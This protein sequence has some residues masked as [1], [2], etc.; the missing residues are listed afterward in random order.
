MEEGA[1]IESINDLK[2]RFEHSIG[3]V[4]SDSDVPRP[5]GKSVNCYE[6]A[7]RLYEQRRYW[8]LV[9]KD[10]KHYQAMGILVRELIKQGLEPVSASEEGGLVVYRNDQCLNHVGFVRGRL[11]RSKWG[12]GGSVWDHRPEEVPI[13]FG[14]VMG[15]YRAPTTEHVVEV[16][17][18]LSPERIQDWYDDNW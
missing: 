2:N 17:G 8:D 12:P 4:L 11:V 1:Q 14:N 6:Y 16:F 3:F 5:E 13:S 18:R 15:Y 10:P 7:F 9:A